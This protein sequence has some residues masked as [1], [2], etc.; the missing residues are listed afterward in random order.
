MTIDELTNVRMCVTDP[1][2]SYHSPLWHHRDLDD[3]IQLIL[4][5]AVSLLDVF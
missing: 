3:P 1:S 2:L 4:K 5:D